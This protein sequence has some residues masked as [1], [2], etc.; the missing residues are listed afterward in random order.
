MKIK[1]ETIVRTVLLVL[2]LA[3]QLLSAAGHPVLPIED[4]DVEALVTA[5]GT[6]ITAL[7]SW[8]KN[9]S[10]TQAALVADEHLKS[11][12]GV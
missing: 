4:S 9:N 3:N 2:A 5:G 1:T 6:I 8:W 7:W 11:L 10:F 12:K